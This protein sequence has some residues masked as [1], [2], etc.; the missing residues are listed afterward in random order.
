MNEFLELLQIYRWSLPAAIVMAAT[1]ALIGAQWT[2]RG[3]SSQI[4][5]LG[6]GSSLGI[7]LGLV[8][9]L[10]MGSDFH[11]VS[12]LVGLSL[13][14]VTLVLSDYLTQNKAD[15]NHIYLTL[16]VLF[17]S[18]TYL[19]SSLSPA[20]ESHIA[21]SYFG[22]LA[23]MSDLGAQACLTTGLVFSVFLVSIWR[24]L[25]MTSFQLINQSL[26]HQNWRNRFFDIGTLL[27]T[28]MAI[29]NMGYLFTIGSLFIAT[30]FAAARSRNLKSYLLKLLVI[31]LTGSSLGFAVS[32]L[33]TTLP[34]VPCVLLGQM[35]IGL[36]AYTKK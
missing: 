4:F 18:L 3:K 13:G 17:L 36:F 27:L 35:L 31:A 30:S 23:V 5:V 28:T 10:A 9:N 2:A 20:L 8:I 1:L 6:Q 26:I 7:V 19:I 16:F 24:S 29:Q 32:L 22:D 11:G 12:L 15:R 14:W 21:A 25:S 33:S 34:T